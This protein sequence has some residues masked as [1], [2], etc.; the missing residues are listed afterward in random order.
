MTPR[1]Y[2]LQHYPNATPINIGCKK[3]NGKYYEIRNGNDILGKGK[4]TKAAWKSSSR[5]I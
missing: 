3:N 1:E 4:S 2:V 5:N